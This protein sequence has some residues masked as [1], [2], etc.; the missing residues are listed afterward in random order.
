MLFSFTLKIDSGILHATT[1]QSLERIQA[2]GSK[3]YRPHDPYHT[4][5]CS[6]L[7]VQYAPC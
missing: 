7:A 1:N 2:T 3:R 6:C 5:L 4:Q